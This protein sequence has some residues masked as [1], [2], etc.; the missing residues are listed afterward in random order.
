MAKSAV[1]LIQRLDKCV[2]HL[3]G[4]S[5]QQASKAIKAGEV[6]VD[7]EVLTDASLKIS[8]ESQIVIAGFNDDCDEVSSVQDAFK[9]RVFMLNKPYDFICA[10]RDKNFRL[11][12]S[13]FKTELK[14]DL[15][16]CVGRLDVDTTGLLIVT[17]DGDLNHRITSPKKDVSKLYYAVLDKAVPEKA[18]QQF[19]H[20]IKHPEEEKRYLPAHL[21]LLPDDEQGRHIACVQL[22][23]GRYHEVKRLFEVVGCEVQLLSRLAIGKLTMGP[24][25]IG[26]YMA[27][28]DEQVGLLFNEHTYTAQEC[29]EL[30][31]TH[32]H[33]L[34]HGAYT[35]VPECYRKLPVPSSID[36]TEQNTSQL[37]AQV[38]QSQLQ[39][40]ASQA[41]H[42]QQPSTQANV[43]LGTLAGGLAV[44]A[45][46]EKVS[47]LANQQHAQASA[48]QENADDNSVTTDIE[49]N[50]YFDEDLDAELDELYGQHDDDAWL[51][52][53]EDNVWLED[54]ED[55]Q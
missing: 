31:K 33:A 24:L 20:G 42:F 4:M 46:L 36:S 18:V 10:D 15:L 1:K 38:S 37:N 3:T 29:L 23:E 14:S 17:D 51:D 7:G 28:N 6:T 48:I 50:P 53:D 45:T 2:S 52:E 32:E 5:R 26:D 39:E 11:V 12:T 25:G 41:D 9:Y 30:I 8:I 43:A 34:E 44:S 49:N 55:M 13:L 21:I 54:D 19:A 47:D 40:Q 22:T 16:H 27:L 35:F